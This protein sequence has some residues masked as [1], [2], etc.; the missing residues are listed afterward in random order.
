MADLKGHIIRLARAMGDDE[1][2]TATGGST[3]G[4]ANSNWIMPNGYWEGAWAYHYTYGPMEERRITAYSSSDAKFTISPAFTTMAA[5]HRV[6]VF[7]QFR[8]RDYQNAIQQA[9]IGAGPHFFQPTVL[10]IGTEGNV[11]SYF[12]SR[13]A[14]IITN[15][16]LQQVKGVETYPFRNIKWTE[17]A[18]PYS[19]VVQLYESP[20]AGYTL[21]IEGIRD[22]IVMID[23]TDTPDV[24]PDH[25]GGYEDYILAAS[26]AWLLRH[27]MRGASG[28]EMRA[29]LTLADHAD[30]R[31]EKIIRREAMPR[32]TT[33]AIISRDRPF[34]VVEAV[35]WS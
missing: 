22:P 25:L 28:E 30:V 13:G 33:R 16:T 11:Y 8:L 5:D 3:G 26:E 14:G 2:I 19:K 29:L 27:E 6:E 31:V 17:R 9:E 32:P 24:P 15:V 23:L 10:S 20:P 7:R 35:S 1:T 4:F 34:N 21:R 18:S 12:S